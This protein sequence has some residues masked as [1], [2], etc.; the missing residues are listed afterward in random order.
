LNRAVALSRVHGP[1]AALEV[2]APLENAPALAGYYLLPS[3]KARLLADI[4]DHSSAAASYRDALSRS[5]TEP[6]RRFLIRRLCASDPT[7][8]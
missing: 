8:P 2:I 6:E 1:A 3:V 5:C 7:Y 4:G